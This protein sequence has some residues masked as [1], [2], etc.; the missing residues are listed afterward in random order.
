MT[1]R[2]AIFFDRDRTL[3]ADAPPGL[4]SP[5]AH[6]PAHL[7]F[8]PG[9]VEAL[10]LARAAGYLVVVVTNQPGPAKGEYSRADVAATHRAL[11]ELCAAAGAPLDGIYVCEHHERGGPG[12]DPALIGPCDCRKPRPGL[13][14]RAARE[15]QID[16]P[17]SAL[18]GDQDRDLQAGRAAGVRSIRVGADFG[19]ADAVRQLLH[20]GD[21]RAVLHRHQ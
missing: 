9:A 15:L 19:V 1:P 14:L 4:A 7:R 10:K 16:L 11:A 3:I 13:L 17:R 20:Q 5:A 6:A 12:G 2:P 21:D 8:L 18:V